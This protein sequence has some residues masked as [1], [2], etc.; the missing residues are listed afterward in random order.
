MCK[1]KG[2]QMIYVFFFFAVAITVVA[3]QSDVSI[4]GTTVTLTCPADPEDTIQWFKYAQ[5]DPL[6][7]PAETNTYSIS[8]YTDKS[9][10]FYYCS[11]GAESKKHHFYIK[12]KVCE[13]C[14]DMDMIVAFGV[15]FADVLITLGIV[16]I[17]YFCAKN[18]AGTAA[19]QRATQ[20]RQP[21]GPARGPPPPDPDYQPLNPAT[22]SNDVY[23]QAHQRR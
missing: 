16:A 22:R 4:S 14:V 15:V 3:G 9:D 5:T 13:G 18:K 10:G 21:R 1:M 6:S 20:S 17:V 23:A 8:N 19:P 12:A 2:C 11:Y 7:L